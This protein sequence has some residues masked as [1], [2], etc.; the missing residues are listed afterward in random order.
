M[1]ITILLFLTVELKRIMY[2]DEHVS[3]LNFSHE[4]NC[5]TPLIKYSK[6]FLNGSS[7]A[8]CIGRLMMRILCYDNV[9]SIEYY[10]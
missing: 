9:S 7:S 6:I 10:E 5:M 3:A 8:T 4:E 2:Q 1:V